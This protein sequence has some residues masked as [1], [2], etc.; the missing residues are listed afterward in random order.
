MNHGLS[1]ESPDELSAHPGEPPQP[2]EL[3]E[4]AA[5][6]E[7]EMLLPETGKTKSTMFSLSFTNY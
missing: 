4:V 1:K 3:E 5:V 6:N 2:H 7:H